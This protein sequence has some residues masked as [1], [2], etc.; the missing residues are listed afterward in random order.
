MG[1]ILLRHNVYMTEI[2]ISDHIVLIKN[3]ES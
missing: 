3:D 1:A 2:D